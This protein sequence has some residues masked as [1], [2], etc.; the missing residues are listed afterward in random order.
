MTGARGQPGKPGPPGPEVRIFSM[1]GDLGEL[2]DGL[3]KL[4]GGGWPVVT[5]PNIWE[6]LY[7]NWK[8]CIYTGHLPGKN[9]VMK[10][11]KRSSE[12]LG[13]KIEIFV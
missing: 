9:D 12:I 8:E 6:T 3:P 13:R 2:G 1:G 10:Y 7:I 5:S 4:R 11:E